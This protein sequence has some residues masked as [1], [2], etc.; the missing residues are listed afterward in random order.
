MSEIQQQLRDKIAEL[1]QIK[2]IKEHTVNL[3]KR[4]SEE[5]KALSEMEKVLDK[6]QRDVE[7]LEKEGLGTMFR[8]FLGDREEQLDKERQEYLRAS[9]RFNELYKSVELIRFELDLLSKKEQNHES[10]RRQ[11]EG[12]IEQREKEI[13]SNDPA[14]AEELKRIHNESDS[15]HQFTAQIEEAFAAGQLVIG[16]IHA[17][18][19]HLIEA[20][21]W[22]QRDIW[23]GRHH[24]SGHIKHQSIDQA[25]AMA[26][27]ARHALIKF[28]N[29]LRDV[30]DNVQLYFNLEIEEFGRFGDIFFDNLIS[31]WLAQQKINKSLHNVSQTRQQI[32]FVMQQ[33]DQERKKVKSKLE[34]L[35]KERRKVIVSG[36]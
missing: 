18:E 3:Q 11:I 30:F 25:R 28:G 22:G 23:G 34:E 2:R 29:E 8:K 4:L 19:Q 20:Q 14:L 21:N 31:D 1:E 13:L 24:G 12:L 36:Q 27:Q 7:A 10:I 15:L 26:M 17:T 9:L 16:F 32:D 5:S 33:L 6:E 35:E